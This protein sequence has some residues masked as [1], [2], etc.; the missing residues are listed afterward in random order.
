MKEKFNVQ[1]ARD[2]CENL[3]VG[4]GQ[5][6]KANILFYKRYYAAGKMLPAALDR[7]EELEKALIEKQAKTIMVPCR[8]DAGMTKCDFSGSD[9]GWC[10]GCVQK[11]RIRTLAREQ[12]RKEGKL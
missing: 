4:G 5:T 9:T 7:I 6:I 8:Y 1:K 12:L 11:G 10:K 2:I 3:P